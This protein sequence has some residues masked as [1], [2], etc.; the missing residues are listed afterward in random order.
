MT[1]TKNK[2]FF[3]IPAL[4]NEDAGEDTAYLKVLQTATDENVIDVFKSIVESQKLI[5]EEDIDYF[6]DKKYFDDLYKIVKAKQNESK[7]N[8]KR[9]SDLAPLLSLLDNIKNYPD[10]KHGNTPIFIN[11]KIVEKG[12]VNAYCE[13]ATDNNVVLVNNDALAESDKPLKIS[14]DIDNPQRVY[15]ELKVYPCEK[16]KMYVWLSK[17]RLPKRI[18][19]TEY[20]KHSGKVKSGKKG[21]TISAMTYSDGEAEHLLQWALRANKVGNTELYLLDIEKHKLI[22]FYDEHLEAPTFHGHEIDESN[23]DNWNSAWRRIRERGKRTKLEKRIKCAADII[24]VKR[25]EII[26]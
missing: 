25:D 17:N 8:R 19:D 2:V 3:L 9:P 1:E 14:T 23:E 10:D 13:Y 15:E 6:F 24:R 22:I 7:K 5:S 26:K 20:E 11:G 21:K 18:Y 12:L 4:T 16:D